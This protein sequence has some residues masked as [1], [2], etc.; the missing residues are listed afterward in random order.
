[1]PISWNV[2]P[3]GDTLRLRKHDT[4]KGMHAV[5]FR[6]IPPEAEDA[7]VYLAE[8]ATRLEKDKE[9][10]RDAY[11]AEVKAHNE[12]CQTLVAKA[13]VVLQ[14]G[15]ALLEHNQELQGAIAEMHRLRDEFPIIVKD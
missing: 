2:G 4:D 14:K 3:V 7:L 15:I 9:A 11:N 8:Q 13:K 6:D 10:Y 5:L 12:T 1:M